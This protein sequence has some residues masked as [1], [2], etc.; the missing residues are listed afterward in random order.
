MAKARDYTQDERVIAAF[1]TNFRMVDVMKVTGLSSKTVYKIRNDPRFQRVLQERK[2]AVL[3]EAV[4]TMRGYMTKDVKILQDIIED[5][6]TSA[7]TKING[8]QLMFNT[9]RDW[10]NTV[11]LLKR[12]EALQEASGFISTT[13]LGVH[14]ENIG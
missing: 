4:E 6:D 13:V 9:F 12:V 8:I 14:G 7:Q 1:L 10:T 3:Q 11:D 5:P 2:D